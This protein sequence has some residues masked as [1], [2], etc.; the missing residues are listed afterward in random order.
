[1]RVDIFDFHLPESNIA[2]EPARPREA[3]KL[4]CADAEKIADKTIADLPSLLQ[5]NDI[6]V[7]NNTR[8]I[9]ARLYGKR[10]E[11]KVEILLHK[12]LPDRRWKSFAR[13]AKRLRIGDEIIFADD[14]SAIVEEKLESG[15]VVVSFAPYNHLS[16]PPCAGISG[17]THRSI[18]LPKI[19]AQ[20]GDDNRGFLEKLTKYGQM[21][22]PP[23]IPR[24]QGNRAEDAQDYQTC[25]AEYDGSVAAP[26]AG[27]HFTPNLLKK[28]QQKGINFAYVTLHVG[29]GTFLPVKVEDTSEHL[30][31]HEWAELTEENLQLIKQAKSKG[32]KVIA[33]GT[34]SLRVL[35]SASASGELQ[36]FMGE[37]NIFITPGYKF[38]TVEKLLTNF[39]LPKSTLFMLVCAFSGI[40]K[41]KNIY[42]HAIENN[43]RFYS[44]GDACLLDLNR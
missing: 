41:M 11:V 27:L 44:Y 10:G 31:H 16:S 15:E 35:E 7:F 6:L 8:V 22:L 21:P 25:Y 29:G 1:L 34:T 43:Y 30:M 28:L 40:D 2:S 14:F 5:P 38:K 33:V 20:G 4:L 9:P 42:N 26:T 24:A 39:H 23:Y 12:E 36:T 32:G 3:A 13:P 19:P 37:T 17:N 18:V